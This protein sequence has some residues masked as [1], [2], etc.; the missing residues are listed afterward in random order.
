MKRYTHRRNFLLFAIEEAFLYYDIT[1][2]YI[3]SLPTS[4]IVKIMFV[5]G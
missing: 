2:I 4:S 3:A 5:D 1:K